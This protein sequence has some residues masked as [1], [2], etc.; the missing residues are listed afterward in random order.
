[1]RSSL[2]SICLAAL[3]VAGCGGAPTGGGGAAGE[4]A[5]PTDLAADTTPQPEP[6]TTDGVPAEAAARRVVAL[7]RGKATTT[8][9]PP[10]TTTRPP[11]TTRPRTTPRPTTTTTRPA[12]GGGS[13]STSGVST[14]TE[15]EV[16]ALV[17]AE[18]AKEGCGPLREDARLVRAARLH[19]ED[20]LARNYFSHDSPD[21]AS[22]TDRARRQGYPAGVGENIAAGYPTPQAVVAGWMDSP[23]HRANILDC[24]Y[25]ATGVG[26]GEGG[27]GY[28]TY[29]TQD[30][31]SV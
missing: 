30:F 11:A 19:S 9:R 18:R 1:V 26:F 28:R 15:R 2:A 7:P 24:D 13:G 31:G 16:L 23:G 29:W 22:P 3:L 21:G 17:N 27:T 14:A 6:E 5:A 4:A 20:M 25:T 8:T 10:T 12:P